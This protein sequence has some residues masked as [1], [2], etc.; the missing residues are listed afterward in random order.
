MTKSRRSQ[1]ASIVV[2]MMSG[3]LVLLPGC[4]TAG[5]GPCG[6]TAHQDRRNAQNATDRAAG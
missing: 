4:Q 1:S 5:A 6:P 2:A 3:A